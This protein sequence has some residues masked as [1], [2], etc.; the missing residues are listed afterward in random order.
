MFLA[1]RLA[2]TSEEIKMKKTFILLTALLPLCFFTA[3]TEEKPAG[4]TA[5]PRS[6][7]TA[8]PVTADETKAIATGAVVETMNTAG[9]TYIQVDTGSEKLWAAAPECS[10]KVGDRLGVP[11]GMLM[12][13]FHSKTL[14]RDFEQIY[15][16]SA[17]VDPAGNSLTKGIEMPA[18]RPSPAGHSPMSRDS[19]PT[20][21]V[22]QVAKAEGGKNVGEIY[23]DKASL[24]GKK[25]T[26]RGK[27]VKFNE[28]I[29]G[30]N[31]LHVRDGSGDAAAHTNDLAVTTNAVAK[32]GDTVLVTGEVHVDK[33]FGAG[34]KYD[35]I[36]EDAQ[37]V[38]E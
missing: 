18:A 25:I 36:V 14:N 3:C 22:G 2:P 33:D 24:S 12:R 17:F 37:V 29:M 23:A 38:V 21:D 4:A 11:E 20:V 27:V 35:V 32:V 26:F 16:V 34:Y 10:V 19:A 13:N 5:S 28:Q 30:R 1:N 6:S 9:Y 15:F 31:W 8:K 7:A